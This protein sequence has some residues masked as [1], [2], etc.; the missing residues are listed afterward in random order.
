[1]VSHEKPDKIGVNKNILLFLNPQNFKNQT[2][3]INEK[4]QFSKTFS[5]NHS[6]SASLIWDFFP[7]MLKVFDKPEGSS[8]H[9]F[10]KRKLIIHLM[11]DIVIK[12]VK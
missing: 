4:S 11:Q 7:N 5:I 12:S 1:M 9:E 2:F 6:I 8:L 10:V 3:N